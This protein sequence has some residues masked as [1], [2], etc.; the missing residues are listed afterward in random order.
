MFKRLT[1]F[2]TSDD[3]K[4]IFVVAV[5]LLIIW[6]LMS[7][8]D[9]KGRVRDNMAGRGSSQNAQPASSPLTRM[10][11]PLAESAPYTEPTT[12]DVPPV[13]AS[14]YSQQPVANPA[15]LLPRDPNSQWAALNPVNNNQPILPDLLQAGNLIGLDTIGQTLK[16]ANL[17][18]RSDPV[19]Q[20]QNVGPW[21]NST[22]EADLGRVPLELGCA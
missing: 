21:N 2:V 7:Y 11:K 10:G 6:A 13:G 20:K 22:Y 5:I 4:W 1:N 17:Q 16:N 8:S 14:N 9:S 12:I 15:D 19:I 18:L 3:G